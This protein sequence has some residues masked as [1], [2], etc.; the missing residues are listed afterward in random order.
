MLPNKQKIYLEKGETIGGTV[1]LLLLHQIR[2][3][4]AHK[5]FMKRKRKSGR[6]FGMW[7]STIISLTILT[8]LI[9][10]GLSMLDWS[11]LNFVDLPKVGLFGQ[12]KML[13]N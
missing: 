6:G 9:V 10:A 13:F 12:I 1:P 11:S 2:P 4:T 3:G 8:C 5:N 7:F